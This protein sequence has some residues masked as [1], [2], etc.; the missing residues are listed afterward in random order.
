VIQPWSVD[1][2]YVDDR[3]REHRV[4]EPTMR[5]L[6]GA[7]RPAAGGRPGPLVV[8][9]GWI[10]QVD[11]V[12]HREDGAEQAVTAGKQAALPPGYHVLI[13]EGMQRTLIVAPARCRRPERR[14]WGVATQLY[15]ARSRASWGIGDLRDLATLR[16]AAQR[17]GA[18]FVLVNPMNA[19]AP[20]DAQENCPYSPVT[21]FF[22]SP[23]YLSIRDVPGAALADLSDLSPV[24]SELNQADRI[25]RDRIWQIK[26]EA[27]Q[28]IRGT[29][30]GESDFVTWRDRQPAEVRRFAVWCAASEVFG[31]ST[32]AW[33][34][35]LQRWTGAGVAPFAERAADRVDFHVWLQWLL[36]LQHERFASGVVHDL[37]V[38]VAPDGADAWLWPEVFVPNV[39]I[40]APPDALNTAGQDWGM[41]PLH[42]GRLRT[43]GYRP[44]V[45]LLRAAMQGAAGIRVDHV[46]GLFRLWFVPSGA[47]PADGAYVRYPA[48][49]LL[50]VLALESDR[51]GVP[52]VGEDLGTVEDGV[53]ERLD[54]RGVL[55]CRVLLLSEEQPN[56]WPEASLASVSTHDLPTLGGL[57]TGADLADQRAAG[58]AAETETARLRQRL[59]DHVGPGVAD[60]AEVV[61]AAHRI[62][63]TAPSTWATVALEDLLGVQHR[64]N[65]PSTDRPE[66]WTQ[67]LPVPVD[68][69]DT[70]LAAVA[71]VLGR[72]APTGSDLPPAPVSTATIPTKVS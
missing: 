72:P 13:A 12:V 57:W 66:N 71:A 14:A 3:G 25:D 33:P 4:P 53:R 64:P 7:L 10:P 70:A 21:R 34:A 35:D 65:I 6:A 23:L 47:G 55:S 60:P 5:A 45:R 32:T 39:T 26:R 1:D 37:P 22:R 50:A 58:V 9:L 36:A 19:A 69:L 61:A 41:A 28:R 29:R 11:G 24:A 46:L 52:V 38:G 56:R 44:F 18:E 63:G 59:A 54:A 20:V 2:R 62:V 49:D 43:D 42:P 30:T 15:A 48:D 68:D 27:L 17:H 31:P 40:G 8:G 51:A 16:T 67:P